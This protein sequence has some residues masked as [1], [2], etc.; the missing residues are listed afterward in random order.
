MHL[1]LHKSP[2]I[3]ARAEESA[4]LYTFLLIPRIASSSKL[5]LRFRGP[6][7]QLVI[8]IPNANLGAQE[9]W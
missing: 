7:L 6:F 2:I 1:D 5:E 9:Y 4:L 8:I 3:T